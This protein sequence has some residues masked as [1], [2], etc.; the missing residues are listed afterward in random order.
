MTARQERQALLGEW[1][2]QLV[3]RSGI[4]LNVRPSAPDDQ[5]QILEF[6]KAVTPAD[7]RFRFLAA[8]RPSDALA[9]LFS[10]VDHSNIESLL[11]FDAGDARLVAIAMIASEGPTSTAEV[12]I[13]VRS[14]LKNKG[15]GWTL[16][17]HSCAFAMARGF[18]RVECI[19][20]SENRTAVSLEEEM[21]F[22]SRSCPG[23][24]T[25]TILSRE[26]NPG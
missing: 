7:L 13:V 19:E 6:L 26:L 17:A 10:N 14:D 18:K 24:A 25:L 1:S 4:H 11:A 3:T 22:Q 8:V 20:S 12:A 5:Q 9:R 16:L 2:A 23:D 21:G 15:I